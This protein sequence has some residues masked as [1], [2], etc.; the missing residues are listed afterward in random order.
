[1]VRGVNCFFAAA[2]RTN[3]VWDQIGRPQGTPLR[4]GDPRGRPLS[5]PRIQP[6][7]STR[8]KGRCRTRKTRKGL[9][10]ALSVGLALRLLLALPP[11]LLIGVMAA[12]EAT[13][14]GA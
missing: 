1:M 8:P 12:I 2:P 9:H 10:L 5:T 3:K 7:S 14:G 4:H 6:V 11:V 13:G